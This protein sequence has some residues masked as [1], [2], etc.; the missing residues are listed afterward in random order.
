MD[1]L[2]AQNEL[3]KIR[4]N[5]AKDPALL[6]DKK[7]ADLLKDLD[8]ILNALKPVLDKKKKI[9]AVLAGIAAVNGD[10]KAYNTLL[11]KVAGDARTAHKEAAALSKADTAKR[12]F[13]MMANYLQ[14]VG[15]QM[16]IDTI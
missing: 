13:F 6:K 3:V 14:L 7:K 16:S 4:A 5:I 8:G 12:D 1:L 15:Q 11:T 9:E 10:I 2:G